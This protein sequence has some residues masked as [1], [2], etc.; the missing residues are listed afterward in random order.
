MWVGVWCAGGRAALASALARIGAEAREE[1][2]KEAKANKSQWR[3]A[4]EELR[5]LQDEKEEQFKKLHAEI[6]RLGNRPLATNLNQK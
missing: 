6:V 5:V 2:E 1:A 3:K 4:L